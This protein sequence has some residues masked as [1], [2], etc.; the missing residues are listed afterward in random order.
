MSVL[1]AA[2]LAGCTDSNGPDYEPGAPQEP[3]AD[4]RATPHDSANWNPRDLSDSLYYAGA[5]FW[6]TP[7]H[8]RVS[9][10]S[11]YDGSYHYSYD[12]F[13]DYDTTPFNWGTADFWL[14]GANFSD[15]LYYDETLQYD[16]WS[17]EYYYEGTETEYGNMGFSFQLNSGINCYLF[18][19]REGDT[20]NDPYTD[21]RLY[22]DANHP[23]ASEDSA[24]DYYDCS[25][26][27][28]VEWAAEDLNDLLQ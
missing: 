19:E 17:G 15:H 14:T 3:Y 23:W 12:Y 10:Y 4:W 7:E 6:E 9:E 16:R 28:P 5:P 8:E 22:Y 18:V 2:L 21:W 25:D 13:L 26:V 24:T 1:I 11:D 20:F 27:F